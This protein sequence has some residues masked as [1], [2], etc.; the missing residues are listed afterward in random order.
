[1]R[2]ALMLALNREAKDADGRPT[3]RLNIIAENLAKLAE[4]GDKDALGAI[5]EVF[6]RVDGRSIQAI[7]HSGEIETSSVARVPMTF[8]TVDAWQAQYPPKTTVQ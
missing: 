3:K 4:Q 2:D 1:M 6:D 8:D 7:E 5:K